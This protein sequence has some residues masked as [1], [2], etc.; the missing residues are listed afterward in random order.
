MFHAEAQVHSVATHTRHTHQCWDHELLPL[1]HGGFLQ[2]VSA[3]STVL[4]QGLVLK[5]MA[6]S[7]ALLPFGYPG[8]VHEVGAGAMAVPPHPSWEPQSPWEGNPCVLDVSK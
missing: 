3:Y 1:H 2:T 5:S 6:S 7:H 4:L 8:E